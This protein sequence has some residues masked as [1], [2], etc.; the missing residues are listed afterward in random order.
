MLFRI[1]ALSA[2]AAAL[3][4]ASAVGL[5]WLSDTPL[6]HMA[7]NASDNT[8]L[9]GP[10]GA[11]QGNDKGDR[12]QRDNSEAALASAES[13]KASSTWAEDELKEAD[14]HAGRL[15]ALADL[16]AASD[17][18]RQA[19]LDLT[20]PPPAP[21]AKP[22][23]GL[24]SREPVV[25]ASRD[26]TQHG[27]FANVV[28]P[29]EVTPGLDFDEQTSQTE[30][31]Y[32]QSHTPDD[33]RLAVLAWSR[34]NRVAIVEESR[35]KTRQDRSAKTEDFKL[36]PQQ[37][38]RSLGRTAAPA[39]S[40][41]ADDGDVF[42]RTQAPSTR[43]VLVMNRDQTGSLL[44][45]LDSQTIHQRGEAQDSLDAQESRRL[46][47]ATPAR[48]QRDAA[49]PDDALGDSELAQREALSEALQATAA[50][51]APLPTPASADA[52][53]ATDAPADHSEQ[54]AS[55]YAE[56]LDNTSRR[57]ALPQAPPPPLLS[58]SAIAGELVVLTIDPYP[59]PSALPSPAVTQPAQPEPNPESQASPIPAA[60]PTTPATP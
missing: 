22:R 6:G 3:L 16:A 27:S 36:K 34:A 50:P 9:P 5:V 40:V 38:P 14:A 53:P 18:Q 24:R 59:V 51:P 47:T 48:P 56:L 54:P 60:E 42:R 28:G 32:L 29:A 7:D 20:A 44:R 37:A 19:G 25:F 11:K 23:Q 33:T 26:A 12:S 31:I 46:R 30:N 49:A 10:A 57:R 35:V 21:A 52:A 2:V 43:L 8:A 39:Q 17:L 45:H 58:Q 1:G 4:I 55:G 41:T 15:D 13:A